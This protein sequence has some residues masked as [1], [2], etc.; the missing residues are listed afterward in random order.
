M[1]QPSPEYLQVIQCANNTYKK[2]ILIFCTPDLLSKFP[3]LPTPERSY[4]TL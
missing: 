1:P 4:F 3:L 2:K